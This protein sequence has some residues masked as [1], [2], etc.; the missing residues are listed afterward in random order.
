M[1]RGEVDFRTLQPPPRWVGGDPAEG[2]SALDAVAGDAAIDQGHR[3][4][5]LAVDDVGVDARTDAVELVAAAG[6]VLHVPELAGAVESQGLRVA[7]SVGPDLR[8]R[9]DPR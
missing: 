9:A 7:V 2:A 1:L 6:A 4:Q 5:Q 8:L 3:A